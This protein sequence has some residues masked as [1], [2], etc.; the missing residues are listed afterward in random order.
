MLD[1]LQYPFTWE[2]V[3]RNLLLEFP[4]YTVKKV[5]NWIRHWRPSSQITERNMIFFFLLI[6]KGWCEAYLASEKML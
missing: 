4:S 1:N 6:K 5:M 3:E 2:L